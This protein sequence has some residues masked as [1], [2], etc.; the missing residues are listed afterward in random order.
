MVQIIPYVIGIVA[1]IFF[2]DLWR[3]LCFREFQVEAEEYS[4]GSLPPPKSWRDLFFVRD[5]CNT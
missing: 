5:F 4:S 1:L 2:V 3:D